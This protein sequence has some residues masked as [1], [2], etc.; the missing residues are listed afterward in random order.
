MSCKGTPWSCQHVPILC[1][2]TYGKTCSDVNLRRFFS[3]HLSDLY[4][5]HLRASALSD[6]S[7][8]LE[9]ASLGLLPK[10]LRWEEHHTWPSTVRTC[11]PNH[12]VLVGSSS[13][14]RLLSWHAESTRICITSACWHNLAGKNSR[15]LTCEC[16][17]DVFTYCLAM[18]WAELRCRPEL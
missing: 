10:E 18:S 13:C 5:A 11:L 6:K 2:R 3:S 15:V 17:V 12:I 9:R 4:P 1:P 7:A 16:F 8:I 14:K